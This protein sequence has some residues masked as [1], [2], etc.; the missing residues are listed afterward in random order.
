MKKKKRGPVSV[1]S[2][3]GGVLERHGLKDQVRRMSAL[4]LW[5]EVVGEGI[6]GVTEA[7]GVQDATLF[8]SVRTSAWLMESLTKWLT[9]GNR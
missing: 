8:V 4:E 3:L 6:A 2:M 1:A 7:T 5:P 9:P